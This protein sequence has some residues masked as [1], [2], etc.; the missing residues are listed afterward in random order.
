[1][2]PE[3]SQAT[4]FFLLLKH[5]QTLGIFHS[6]YFFDSGFNTFI[7]LS[8]TLV[9]P[10]LELLAR[11]CLDC[12]FV[13]RPLGAQPISLEPENWRQEDGIEVL[14]YFHSV[15]FVWF[16]YVIP[17][18]WVLLAV[19]GNVIYWYGALVLLSPGDPLP[20]RHKSQETMAV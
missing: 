19:S 10:G 20:L 11:R 12:V 2:S 5:I 18:I 7:Y 6:P 17:S 4:Y 1:M 3:P 14:N 9:S 13:L 15:S 8:G 16:D